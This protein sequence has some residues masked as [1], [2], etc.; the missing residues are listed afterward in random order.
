MVSAPA[1]ALNEENAKHRAMLREVLARAELVDLKLPLQ[2]SE[3]WASEKKLI[4]TERQAAEA[5]KTAKREQIEKEIARL[6]AE[7]DSL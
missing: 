6:Q 3:W 7:R 5:V 2:I 4:E 1:L